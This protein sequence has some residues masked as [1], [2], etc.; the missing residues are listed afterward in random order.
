MLYSMSFQTVLEKRCKYRKRVSN[1][2]LENFYVDN[3]FDLFVSEQEAIDTMC[4]I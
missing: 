4:K 2:I 1:A 3:Y